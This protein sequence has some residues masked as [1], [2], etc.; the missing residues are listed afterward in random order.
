MQEY[1]DII[2]NP[3]DFGTIKEKL[4]KNEYNDHIEYCDDVRLVFSNAWTFNKKGTNVYKYTTEV[5]KY[6]ETRMSHAFPPSPLASATSG[7]PFA[8]F[9]RD[10]DTSVQCPCCSDWAQD[11]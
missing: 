5:S 4:L 6:F 8:H 9:V 7:L 11:D 1:L 3:M 10:A 2:K